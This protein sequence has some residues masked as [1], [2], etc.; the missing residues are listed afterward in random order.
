M[1]VQAPKFCRSGVLYSYVECNTAPTVPALLATT[2][3]PLLPPH[4]CH[5][6]PVITCYITDPRQQVDEA[7]GAG[8]FWRLPGV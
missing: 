8:L 4:T 3:L 2:S 6:L 1:H 7:A 5:F